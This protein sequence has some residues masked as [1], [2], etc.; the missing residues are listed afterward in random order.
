MGKKSRRRDENK[1]G[2]SAAEKNQNKIVTNIEK[3]DPSYL[4]FHKLPHALSRIVVKSRFGGLEP[5]GG[6]SV[7]ITAALVR[8]IREARARSGHDVFEGEEKIWDARNAMA[9]DED[10]GLSLDQYIGAVVGTQFA[11]MIMLR[12]IGG[13]SIGM[14]IPEMSG[15]GILILS[16]KTVERWPRVRPHWRRFER[17]LCHNCSACAHLAT[18]RYQV[19]SGCGVARYCSLQCQRE[20]WPRHQEECLAC[21]EL[22]R[23]WRQREILARR[24]IHTGDTS[25][26]DGDGRTSDD[27]EDDSLHSLPSDPGSD[28]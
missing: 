6:R 25:D 8:K 5:C 26:D 22:A 14:D 7:K 13:R 10:D 9:L 17:R 4:H 11:R 28:A 24:G 19:C 20:H 15:R 23:R 21:Q 3:G 18:P 27:E 2:P 16:L 12:T 1:R